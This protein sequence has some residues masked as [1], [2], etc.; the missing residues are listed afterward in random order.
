MPLSRLTGVVCSLVFG[1]VSAAIGW[2]AGHLLAQTQPT[3]GLPFRLSD[4]DLLDAAGVAAVAFST[5][6]LNV[7][8][9]AW[10]D[11]A[12]LR[13]FLGAAL[14]LLLALYAAGNAVKFSAYHQAETASARVL[15][16]DRYSDGQEDLQAARERLKELKS[17]PAYGETAGCTRITGREVRGLCAKIA[18][19][20][21]AI[22]H[23]RLSKAG[24]HPA[25]SDASAQSLAWVTGLPEAWIVKFWPVFVALVFELSNCLGV[26]ALSRPA[27]PAGGRQRLAKSPRV[28]KTASPKRPAGTEPAALWTAGP[29][30]LAKNQSRRKKMLLH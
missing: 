17:H 21:E 23:A 12:S 5:V 22:Q 16:A 15:A 6:L 4:G 1:G 30:P 13:A 29:K 28:K 11:G 27:K 25:E 2:R 18:Q 26:F 14:W 9:A 19:G 8:A 10:R 24:G 20:E 7:A 3:G